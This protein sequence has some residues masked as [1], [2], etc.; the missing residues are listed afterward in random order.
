MR[1]ELRAQAA[2]SFLLR[3][4]F[5]LALVLGGVWALLHYFEPCAA[6]S[7]CSAVPLIRRSPFPRRR[8]GPAH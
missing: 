2:V 1:A 8:R 3:F 5:M 7:L 6:A 4:L